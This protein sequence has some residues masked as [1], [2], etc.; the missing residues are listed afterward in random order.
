MQSICSQQQVRFRK[1]SKYYIYKIY[2]TQSLDGEERVTKSCCLE[3]CTGD[4]VTLA[5][6]IQ[7][8]TPQNAISYYKLKYLALLGPCTCLTLSLLSTDLSQICLTH[9]KPSAPSSLCRCGF[10]CLFK[11]PCSYICNKCSCSNMV[12]IFP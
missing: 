6:L 9:P 8:L 3:D 4:Q 7:I 10:D 1:L 11:F 2:I 5:A 12:F